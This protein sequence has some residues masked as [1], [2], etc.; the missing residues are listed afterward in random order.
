MAYEWYFTEKDF[1]ESKESK[2]ED[3]IFGNICYKKD[4]ETYIIDIHKEYYNHKENGYDLEVYKEAENDS[5]GKWLGS[6]KTIKSSMNL[7][8][9]TKRAERII[10]KFLDEIKTISEEDWLMY[11]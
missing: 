7:K 11:E 8:R 5:H 3:D 2:A 4:D 10:D 9:F 1:K 6:I